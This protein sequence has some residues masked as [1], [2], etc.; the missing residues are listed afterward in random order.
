MEQENKKERQNARKEYISEIRSLVEFI[1]R[2]D[3]RYKKFKDLLKAEEEKRQEE[4]A[5]KKKNDAEFKAMQYKIWME[6]KLEEEKLMEKE[7]LSEQ[8][9]FEEDIQVFEC[10]ACNKIF[11][12]DKQLISHENS[13][14]H[15][16]AVALLRASLLE[17]EENIIN[18]NT[19]CTSNQDLDKFQNDNED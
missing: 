9:I 11:K 17:D 3:P 2:R 15:K 16:D 8:E 1:R 7:H 10:Y 18:T 4:L 5:Q 13:K 12:S 6:E 14:K 19:N